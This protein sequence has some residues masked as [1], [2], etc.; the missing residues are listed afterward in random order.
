MQQCWQG[1]DGW[2]GKMCCMQSSKPLA[3]S[4]SCAE[5]WKITNSHLRQVIMQANQERVSLFHEQSWFTMTVQICFLEEGVFPTVA[6]G[7]VRFCRGPETTLWP[8]LP[9][10]IFPAVKCLLWSTYGLFTY[11]TLFAK[12]FHLTLNC[13]IK[14]KLISTYLA[15]PRHLLS[16]RNLMNGNW[17]LIRLILSKQEKL[18]SK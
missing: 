10:T 4:P 13:R 2:Q 11:Q 1:I 18:V 15:A 9:L 17:V 3:L 16:I 7:F 14:V 6:A 8:K 5:G 12:T